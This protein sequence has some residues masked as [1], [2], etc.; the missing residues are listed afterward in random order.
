VFCANS[1]VD[2]KAYVGFR[3]VTDK[4]YILKELPQEVEVKILCCGCIEEWHLIRYEG[5]VNVAR[6]LKKS[7]RKPKYKN[8]G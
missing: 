6:M 1:I 5:T 4:D 7:C 2:S 3:N 8:G